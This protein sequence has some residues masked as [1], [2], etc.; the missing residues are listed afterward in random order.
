MNFRLWMEAASPVRALAVRIE[1][2][3]SCLR[4]VLRERTGGICS[5]ARL[6]EQVEGWVIGGRF[7]SKRGGI[8]EYS[9]GIGICGWNGGAVYR[10]I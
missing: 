9:D 1:K 7:E 5:D 10:I 4:Y 8:I 6:G 2:R 3:P